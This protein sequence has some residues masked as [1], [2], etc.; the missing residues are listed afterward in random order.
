MKINKFI[1]WAPRIL[2][3]LFIL[4]LTLFSL[5]IFDGCSG[6]FDCFLGLFMHNISSIVLIVLLI[7]AW[8]HEWV[9][10]IT[11]IVGGLLYVCLTLRTILANGFQWYYL[12]WIFQISGI[13]F[14]IGAL[15]FWNWKARKKI[16]RNIKKN[17]GNKK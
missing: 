11:F 10:G 12:A 8:K 13:A 16:K 5:D 2:S 9:G 3:I 6:F 7:V 1:Y 17:R 14:I 4:F 15:W